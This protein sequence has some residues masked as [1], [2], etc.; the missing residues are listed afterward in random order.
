M[1]DTC[2]CGCA[3][4]AWS[5]P[6]PVHSAPWS[7]AAV[8]EQEPAPRADASP[9]LLPEDAIGPL[10]EDGAAVPLVDQ[11]LIE[12]DVLTEPRRTP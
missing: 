12:P 3:L 8:H 10:P 1:S 7:P 9:A 6:W 2:P 5:L 4:A 11:H